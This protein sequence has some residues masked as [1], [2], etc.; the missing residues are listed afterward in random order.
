M[1]LSLG[2]SAASEGDTRGEMSTFGTLNID[3]IVSVVVENYIVH[4]LFVN[5]PL[6]PLPFDIIEICTSLASCL[7][8]KI[9][10]LAQQAF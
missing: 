9:P 8:F 2:L 10:F 1:S 4:I 6:W 5:N 3:H 7:S